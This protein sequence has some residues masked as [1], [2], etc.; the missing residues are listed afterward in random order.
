M[1]IAA[2][3]LA[4]L[5]LLWVTT[6]KQQ[7]RRCTGIHFVFENQGHGC[8]LTEDVVLSAM[9]GGGDSITGKPL[10]HVDLPKIKQRLLKLP[11]V[12]DA[13][14]YFTLGGMLKVRLMQRAIVARLYD[15]HGGSAYLSDDGILMPV[16]GN[17]AE[18]VLIASGVINDTLIRMVGKSVFSTQTIAPLAE[19][20][21]VATFIMQDSLYKTL[22]AQVWVNDNKD[23]DLIPVIDDH[24][25]RIGNA[26]SLEYKLHK[27][28][29]FYQKGM[30]R[31]GW[32]QYS[33]INLKYSNQVIC[34]NKQSK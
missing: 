9:I 15:L 10:A 26:D 14:L 31:T 32:D 33:L 1:L 19:V 4:L 21:R 12:A 13:D 18:R 5:V 20:A 27:L 23:L 8:F 24:V 2:G 34:T 3:G 28:T 17:S 7:E 16:P 6:R 11:Y 29:A 22:I 30:I 25:V